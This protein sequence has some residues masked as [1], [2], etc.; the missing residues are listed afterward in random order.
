MSAKDFFSIMSFLRTQDRFTQQSFQNYYF[1]TCTFENS[2]QKLD[3]MRA[4]DFISVMLFLR[5]QSRF[6]QQGF[7]ELLLL[8]FSAIALKK[9]LK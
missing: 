9:N 6:T 5:T 8:S 2:W 3:A 1:I 4:K 7:D